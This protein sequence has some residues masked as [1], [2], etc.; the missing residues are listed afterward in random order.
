MLKNSWL[1]LFLIIVLVLLSV[2]SAGKAS[3]LSGKAW[4]AQC[5]LNHA[6]SQSESSGDPIK[7]WPW[8]DIHPVAKLIVPRLNKTQIVLESH[9]SEAMAF[10]PG[11]IQRDNSFFLAG[12]RDSHFAFL[13]QLVIGDSVE[14]RMPNGESHSATIQAIEIIDTEKQKEISIPDNSIIL[15]TC[16]PFNA[17]RAGGPLRY[18]AVVY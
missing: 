14:L 18:V 5:L 17:V 13:S 12:H 3:Y 16:Y 4:L 15:L 11:L 8:A 1:K 9:S 6:W 10:G 7:P 2:G